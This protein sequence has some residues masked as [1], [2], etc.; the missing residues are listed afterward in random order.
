M[1]YKPSYQEGTSQAEITRDL[2]VDGSISGHIVDLEGQVMV[3]YVRS[4]GD[5]NNDGLTPA[6]AWATFVY[7]CSQF[8]GHVDNGCQVLDITGIT[9]ELPDN[10]ILPSVV[11]NTA[12]LGWSPGFIGLAYGLTIHS[13]L[14]V[15]NIVLPSNITGVVINPNTA[16][17]TIQTNLVFGIN[18]L[19][20]R[21]V[22][23]FGIP[24]GVV[25]SNTGTDILV[26][27]SALS[28][29][30]P[31]EISLPGAT[32]TANAGSSSTTLAIEGGPYTLIE[33]VS[34]EAPQAGG[35][36]LLVETPLQTLI[37][38]CWV[39]SFVSFFGM[40]LVEF[41]YS[42]IFPSAGGNDNCFYQNLLLSGVLCTDINFIAANN[43]NF[44]A[45]Q[46]R[47]QGCGPIFCSLTSEPRAMAG[48]ISSCE[49]I[50]STTN[51]FLMNGSGAFTISGFTVDGSGA[52]PVK[53][54]GTIRVDVSNAPVG[55]GNA[56]FG[57]EL[58]DGAHCNIAVT[59]TI[60]AGAG[61]EVKIGN[62]AVTTYAAIS[63]APN[64][65]ISDSGANGDLSTAKA[66]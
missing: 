38:G 46:I 36:A 33:G 48:S 14:H 52:S 29:V 39:E 54:N 60:L 26:T 1:T 4:G 42:Y 18:A 19:Q 51:A 62:L 65:R 7:G 56:G 10:F 58:A 11:T 22:S 28:A 8:L 20:G 32:L 15:T 13:D 5:N 25:R 49:V 64:H 40:D 30:D 47:V 2:R 9:E 43:S 31:I 27:A 6:T 21:I 61:G 23:Q 41:F 50:N 53:A 66:S 3:R 37:E 24:M 59:T 34:L 16:Q 57:I 12:F 55:V 17:Q 45:D 35:F 63:A 44:Q